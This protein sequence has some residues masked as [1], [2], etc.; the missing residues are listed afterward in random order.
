M[1]GSMIQVADVK[2]QTTVSCTHIHWLIQVIFSHFWPEAPLIWMSKTI[3]MQDSRKPYKSMIL[4]IQSS[5][6]REKMKQ[7]LSWQKTVIRFFLKKLNS[8][9]FSTFKCYC[10]FC[11]WSHKCLPNSVTVIMF[12]LKCQSYVF[13]HFFKICT[14]TTYLKITQLHKQ[15][16]F[17]MSI[18]YLKRTVG[19]CSRITDAYHFHSPKC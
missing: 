13:K 16:N 14:F 8:F 19:L 18:L 1:F 2:R 7:I 5:T 15:N 3:E 6:H 10:S 17:K 9:I 12:T 4:C 11:S